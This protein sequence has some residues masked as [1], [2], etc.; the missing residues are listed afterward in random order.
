VDPRDLLTVGPVTG[1]RS[2]LKILLVEDEP[3]ILMDIE[4]QLQAAGHDVASVQNADR[5]IEI[6]IKHRVD[7][8][9]TDIDMPGSMDGLR[10][11]AAVR[12]RWPPIQIVVMSGKKRPSVDELPA[13]A[14]FLPKPVK[15]AELL[16]AID[17]W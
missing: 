2:G 4:F 16:K 12:D 3:L 9:L 6:L 10:L 5:A 11:A 17:V 13:R 8:I 15:P 1:R 14:R 7:L